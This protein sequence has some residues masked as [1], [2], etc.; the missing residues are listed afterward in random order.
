[1]R[2]MTDDLRARFDEVT[3]KRSV[4]EASRGYYIWLNEAEMRKDDVTADEIA[5]YIRDYRIRDNL[6]PTNKL[7]PRFEARKD[8]RL[9]LTALTP[10]GLEEALACARRRRG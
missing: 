4:I 6:S 7:T 10:D 5:E 9:Y 1:M 3:P 8:Q 2:E